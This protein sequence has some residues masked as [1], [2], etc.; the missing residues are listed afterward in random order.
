MIQYK[1]NSNILV[2][3][4]DAIV[5]AVNCQG[6]MGAGLAKQFKTKYPEMFLAYEKACD[7][8][9]VSPGRN[10]YWY[11]EKEKQW[12][13]NF[14]TKDSWKEPS[15]YSYISAGLQNL[16]EFVAEEKINSISIPALGCG[17]G[18][19]DFDTVDGMICKAFKN[20]NGKCV[21]YKNV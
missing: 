15:E 5:N 21:I 3:K 20:Y 18:G 7:F 9:F 13:V 4:D 16:I 17:L 11:D 1:K 12:I 2:S 19:L 10:H 6:I 14:V 8:G